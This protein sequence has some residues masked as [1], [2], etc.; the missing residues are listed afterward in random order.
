MTRAQRGRLAREA[1]RLAMECVE[2]TA[3][4]MNDFWCGC[5]IG[6]VVKRAGLTPD[7][8]FAAKLDAM[9]SNPTDHPAYGIVSQATRERIFRHNPTAVVFPLLALADALEES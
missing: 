2:G 1:R 9:V 7:G 3:P 6:I 8:W 5:A 4:E